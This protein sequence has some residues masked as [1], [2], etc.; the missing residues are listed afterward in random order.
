MWVVRFHYIP[1]SLTSVQHIT[2]EFLN[3]TKQK[4][5]KTSKSVY[6]CP[7]RF[8]LQCD[9]F[10][11]F[12]FLVLFFFSKGVISWCRCCWWWWWPGRRGP[13]PR[14]RWRRA[15]TRIHAGASSASPWRLAWHGVAA[16]NLRC[17]RSACARCC[18]C[19]SSSLQSLRRHRAP[20]L[21][22]QWWCLG[23]GKRSS[24]S[25]SEGSS[26]AVGWCERSA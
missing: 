5:S 11:G 6:T 22:W 18:E 8:Y 2:V 20:R 14:A 12:V 19:R 24:V 16:R 17:L 3:K 23:A 26:G 21:K 15:G 9:E 25:T 13:S 10:S 1:C 4:S 7:L